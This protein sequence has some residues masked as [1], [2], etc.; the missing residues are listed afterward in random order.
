MPELSPKQVVIWLLI[1]CVI[2]MIG[3]RALR[4]GGDSA[5]LDSSVFAE[6]T[7]GREATAV[8]ARRGGGGRRTVWVHVAGAVRRPGVYRLPEGS[9][10]AQALRRA[11]G[12]RPSADLDL[13]NLAA[14]V[15]D[16]QQ[17]LIPRRGETAVA[18]GPRSGA[19]GAA[20]PT[21]DGGGTSG[22]ASSAGGTGTAGAPISLA[23]ATTEQLETIDG[24]GPV[25]AGKI[26]EFRDSE[27]GIGSIEELDAIPGVGPATMET[28]RQALV[29]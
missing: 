26:L 18:A 1:A 3:G 7:K 25:T 6:G 9:R 12:E 15:T 4:G 23:T 5:T 29:P 27:G 21:S 11:G 24:I 28:L 20:P 19:G 2:L 10:V 14:A 17:V 13:I 16:G 8:R 22:I